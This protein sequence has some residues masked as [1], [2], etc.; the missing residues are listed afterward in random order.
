MNHWPYI[1]YLLRLW[2]DSM[3]R[4]N[5][6]LLFILSLLVTRLAFAAADLEIKTIKGTPGTPFKLEFGVVNHGPAAA[7]NFG[8]N[9]YFYSNE[10]LIVSQTFSL[11]PLAAGATRQEQLTLDFPSQGATNIKVEVFD[12]Q[13]PDTQPSTNFLQMNLRGPSLR[14]ADLQI[15]DV[16]TEEQKEKSRS[17]LIVKLHNNGPDRI[18]ASQLGVDLEVFGD[19]IA[20]VD[21]RV[22]RMDAS[23]DLETR[24][25]IPNAPVVP[26]TNGVL[27]LRWASNDVED[28]DLSNNVYRMPVELT[29]RMPDLLPGKMTIDKQGVLSFSISNKGNA[30]AAASVTAL[31]INGALVERYNTPEIAP[32]GVQQYRYNG[33]KLTPDSTVVIVA[34]FNADVQEAS[35]E[36]NRRD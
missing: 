36:N 4:I 32:H 30:R 33:S 3:R 15:V 8:C 12:S 25:P 6:R 16:K 18:A 14:K 35:E 9:V 28:A 27:V 26:A 23:A 5:M 11:N 24:L 13:Q 21:K 22:E 31:Y 29:L 1:Y 2:Q 17:I 10:R 7:Q 19:V 20:H 34:D